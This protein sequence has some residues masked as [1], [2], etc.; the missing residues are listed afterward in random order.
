MAL[1][2]LANYFTL[3]SPSF[4]E[5]YI[6]SASFS[7]RRVSSLPSLSLPSSFPLPSSLV[8][9]ASFSS[10]SLTFYPFHHASLLPSLSSPSLAFLHPA[11]D[12]PARARPVCLLLSARYRTTATFVPLVHSAFSCNASVVCRS[13]DAAF[14]CVHSTHCLK[15]SKVWNAVC[16]DGEPFC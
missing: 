9:Q 1:T 3:S 10:S 15:F 14:Y 6:S 16:V 8:S 7:S 4:T 12:T 2:V 13:V 5:C 11:E